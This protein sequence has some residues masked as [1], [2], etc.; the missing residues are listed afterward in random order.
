MGRPFLAAFTWAAQC[1]QSGAGTACLKGKVPICSSCT[2]HQDFLLMG[3]SQMQ[4][5]IYESTGMCRVYSLLLYVCLLCTQ[6]AITKRTLKL[7]E[8]EEAEHF[9]F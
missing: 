5:W 7:W 6:R 1:I 8:D 2:I 3:Y 9:Y 4:T